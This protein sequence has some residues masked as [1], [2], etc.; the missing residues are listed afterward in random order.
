[1]QLDALQ[2]DT[3]PCHRPPA[4]G[5]AVEGAHNAFPKWQKKRGEEIVS[6]LSHGAPS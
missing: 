1:M 2:F 4:T 6:D 5:L 3:A